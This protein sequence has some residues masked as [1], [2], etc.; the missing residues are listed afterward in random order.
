MII[1]LPKSYKI[2]EW[3]RK[4]LDNNNIKIVFVN[5]G[6]ALG[7]SVLY[8][9]EY[10]KTLNISEH[11]R[12]LYGDT[13]ILSNIKDDSNVIA[14]SNSEDNYNWA[15]VENQNAYIKIS[16]ENDVDILGGDIL[17]GYFSFSDIDL[18]RECLISNNYNFIEAIKSYH[19]KSFLFV[20]KI[21]EWL[22]FGHVNT[23]YKS[24]MKYTTQRAFNELYINSDWVCKSSQDYEKILAEANWFEKIPLELKKYIPQ[25]LGKESK[26][27]KSASYK[28]E[29][30]CHTALNELYVFSEL[31]LT[32]WKSILEKCL[33]FVRESK[34]YIPSDKERFSTINELLIDKTNARLVSFCSEKQ[35][36]IN[37]KWDFKG[38]RISVSDI[39]DVAAK[40][41][42]NDNNP[43]LMHGDLC[44]SNILFDFRAG[45]IKLIDPRGLSVDRNYTIYGSYYYDLAKLSHSILGMYDW[46]VAGYC[47]ANICERKIELSF[48]NDKKIENIKSIFID[49]ITAQFDITLNEL[50][51]MQIYL[52]LSMLPLH[53]DDVQR[54]KALFAN[55][56]RLY[57]LLQ[58][59]EK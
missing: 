35:F 34:S 52:F 1:T 22:D 32:V 20:R 58:E 13:L 5:D 21:D 14:V 57:E 38:K 48:V 4:W 51:A 44:F 2:S 27:N 25:Y 7:E 39:L 24:K 31:P 16:T 26:N 37:D 6:G 43:S 40:Y 29:Y 46:I 54:Q 45:R 30:L 19:A 8:A 49:M 9:I 55:V 42:P 11:L 36:S 10:I 33:D 17:C 59:I 56:F 41:I 3:D 18:L 15:R 28:L 53:S 23:Y 12:I 47:D 50:Y